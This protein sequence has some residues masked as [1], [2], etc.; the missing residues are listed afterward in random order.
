MSGISTSRGR[1]ISVLV[2]VV[3]D[4]LFCLWSSLLVVRSFRK[5]HRLRFFFLPR[6]LLHDDTPDTSSHD[7]EAVSNLA[8]LADRTEQSDPG[9]IFLKA[10]AHR[11]AYGG[12]ML[13]IF[14]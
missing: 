10:P 1:I 11:M 14:R 2:S 3:I 8:T 5:V 4:H 12:A 13:D 9:V 7:E 6:F